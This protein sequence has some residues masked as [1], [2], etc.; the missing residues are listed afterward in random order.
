MQIHTKKHNYWKL[1]I[2]ILVCET[3]GVISGLFTMNDIDIWYQSLHKPPFNPPAYIFAPVWATL[4][5]MMGI[6]WW[7]ILE[8]DA[9]K[10]YKSKAQSF[11]L[12]QLFLNFW[13][14]I[15]FFKFHSPVLAL[16]DIILMIVSILFTIFSFAKISRSAAWLLVPYILWVGFATVLNYAIWVM[17]S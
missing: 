14:S 15:L 3:V 12:L 9:L 2:T 1:A 7:L 17:N 16:V 5:L 4:Y 8:S 6:A 10:S 11:F 13:W